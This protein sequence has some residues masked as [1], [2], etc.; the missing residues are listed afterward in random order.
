ML[1]VQT[2]IIYLITLLQVQA[3]TECNITT[4]HRVLPF[5]KRAG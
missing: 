5:R 1:I 3:P 4:E 2:L